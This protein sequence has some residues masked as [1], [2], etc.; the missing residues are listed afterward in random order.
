MKT[1]H[2]LAKNG[3]Q[4]FMLIGRTDD[5]S[6]IMTYYG[7]DLH[8]N[9]HLV[10]IPVLRVNTILRFSWHG[11]FHFFCLNTITRIIKELK[12]D[13]IYLTER[14]LTRFLLRK[15][16]RLDLPFVY[17]IHGLYAPEYRR[18]DP[19][20]KKIFQSCDAL[21]TTTQ[22]LQKRINEL[23]GSLPPFFRVP[24]ATDLP[25]NEFPF[26]PPAAGEPWRIGYV[27]QL[28]PLQGV[29]LVIRAL[30]LLP[31]W[32]VVDIIGGKKKHIES[33]RKLAETENV[34][35]RV[36]FHGFVPPAEV[37]KRAVKM[38][39]FVLPCLPEDKMPH[40]AHTKIYE[41]MSF[42]RPIV[43][44]NLPSVQE[45]IK[46]GVNGTLFQAGDVGSLAQA[47]RNLVSDPALA[48]VM[49]GEAKKHARLF[50]WQAR[51]RMLEACFYR[52]LEKRT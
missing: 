29:D 34:I 37:F 48:D 35:D 43:A 26:R 44:A 16:P 18:P 49:A 25:G 38:H 10:Q 45:E 3:H 41:Y 36:K 21:I 15:K 46:D 40:V 27:G 5:D 33:L 28:Y 7:L 30:T 13:L 20:E 22:S 9:L 52:V 1:C 42:G 31:E 39:L 6:K 23:Y 19:L 50:S 8:P 47:I 14:K 24:L 32:I 4:V 12:P 17:E 11:V 2:A 51:A